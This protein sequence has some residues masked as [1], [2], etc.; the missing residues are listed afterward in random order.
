MSLKES[1][2]WHDKEDVIQRKERSAGIRKKGH[3]HLFHTIEFHLAVWLMGYFVWGG[4]IY[5]SMGMF[6]HSLC[7]FV[8]L[9]QKDFLYRREYL[10]VN[11]LF[12][13]RSKSP[14]R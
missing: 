3:F 5:V 12:R 4:F 14:H 1:L 6:F 8:Y 11:W 2:K 10:F 9:I 7:D 13:K